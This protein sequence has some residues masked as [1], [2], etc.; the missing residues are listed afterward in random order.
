M[1]LRVRTKLFVAAFAVGALTATAAGAVLAWWQRGMA[2]RRIEQSLTAET[3]LVAELVTAN[4][5]LAED[6]LDL[7]ADRL[8]QLAGVRV[9]FIG[10]DGRVLGDS[11]EDGPGLAAMENHAGRPEIVAAAAAHDQVLLRRYSTTTEVD[12]LYAATPVGHPVVR[13][14]RLALPLAEIRE[15]QRAIV[16]LTLASV[17]TSLPVA[18]LL[19][20]VLSA[21]LARRVSAVA[22][23]AR[24]YATGDMRRPA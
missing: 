24:Q 10:H 14:V 9:T 5:A 17:L 22:T 8:G 19:A 11:S 16:L 4:T 21:P 13:Y 3:H 1:T 18:A 2:V 20:W 23:V 15:Q 12:T 6:R 7:E